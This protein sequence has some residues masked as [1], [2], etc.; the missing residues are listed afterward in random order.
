MGFQNWMARRGNV[1][2]TA[3]AVANCWR[4]FKEKNPAMSHKEISEAYIDLRYGL[5]REPHLAKAVLN[6]MKENKINPLNLS[7]NILLAEN[8]NEVLTVKEHAYEW[9]K[10]MKEEIEKIG[11][12]AE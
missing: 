8:A 3:R 7:W 10:I 1:G 2:G 4:T 9:K 5:T 6:L 11:V 12:T